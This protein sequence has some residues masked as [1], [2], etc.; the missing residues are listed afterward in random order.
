MTELG[1]ISE[2]CNEVVLITAATLSNKGSYGPNYGLNPQKITFNTFETKV[3]WIYQLSIQ[4]QNHFKQ[5]V[6][7]HIMDF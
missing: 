7:Y 2:F 4:L 1:E 6:Y 3:S 5:L